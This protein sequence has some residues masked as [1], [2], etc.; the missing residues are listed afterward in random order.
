MQGK[1]R[2]HSPLSLIEI[3]L[4]HLNITDATFS[5]R[6]VKVTEGVVIRPARACGPC[7]PQQ[8]S[9]VRFTQMIAKLNE[10]RD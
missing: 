5:W 3:R 9:S 8:G 1:R 10:E 6:G 2:T 4:Q 7:N